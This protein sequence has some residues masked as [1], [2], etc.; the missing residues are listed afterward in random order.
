M[1]TTLVATSSAFSAGIAG[2]LAEPQVRDA[3]L[4]KR[5]A[6]ASS[7]TAV[8]SGVLTT[9]AT[10]PQ[11]V[12]R[13]T[14]RL[15]GASIPSARLAGTDDEGKF[16]FDALPA[17]SY[18]LSATK[19]GYVLTFYGSRHPGRGPGVPVAIV[20]GQ[21]ANVALTIVT[22]AVITGTIT[23]PRGM[24]APNVAVTAVGLSP[25]GTSATT[26]RGVTDDRGTYRLFGLAPGDYLISAVRRVSMVVAGRGA[27]GDIAG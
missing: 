17:G 9:G 2:G 27:V 3:G 26:L 16:V 12:R 10:S 11:P 7:G 23:D 22:G 19:P 24:P 6:V 20:D 18:T 4:P 8:L 5:D 1:R 14:I 13:A 21:R 25:Q 15:S